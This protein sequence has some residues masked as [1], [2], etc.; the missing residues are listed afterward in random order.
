MKMEDTISRESQFINKW[1]GYT[2]IIW[3]LA[4]GDITKMKEIYKLNCHEFLYWA[5][6]MIDKRKVE[7]AR[8]EKI[9]IIN[10]KFICS[11]HKFFSR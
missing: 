10:V 2:E 6:Y 3:L 4:G 11:N 1:G 8:L 9:I 7:V 5:A